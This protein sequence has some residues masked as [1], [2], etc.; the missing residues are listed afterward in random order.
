MNEGRPPVPTELKVIRGTDQPS[1]VKKD[2][3]Q[4]QRLESLPMAPEWLNEYAKDE[5][6]AVAEQLHRLKMLAS[7]DMGLLAAYCQQLGVFQKAQRELEANGYTMETHNGF[8]VPSPWVAIGNK[9]LDQ[10]AKIGVQF[11]LTPASR[12][13]IPQPKQKEANPFKALKTGTNG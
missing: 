12:T 6:Y 4:P 1:R 11:G 9:A 13:R 2:Q 10:A 5:W 7:V 8:E 3:M